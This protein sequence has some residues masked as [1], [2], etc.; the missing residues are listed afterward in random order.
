MADDS[1]RYWHSLTTPE[2]RELAMRDPVVILPVAAIEQHG[3][4]LPLSTDLEI[5]R[6]ILEVCFLR[7]APGFPA[8]ALPPQVVG[9]SLEHLRFPGTLSLSP[10]ILGETLFQ[11]GEAVAR[12]GVRRLVFFNSHGGNR[13]VL[14]AAALRLRAELDVLVVKASYPRFPRPPGVDLPDPEWQHGFHGGAVETSMMLHLRSDLVR[15]EALSDFPSLGQ[16]LRGPVGPEGVAPFAWLAGDLNPQGV[17]GD[18]RKAD[19][20]SGARMVAHYGE[21]LA[22]IVEDTRNF[23]LERLR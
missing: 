12:S 3:P 10:E 7:L 8:W 13:P 17:V 18:P 14:D 6:G 5:G 20:S 22:E 11:L 4:H 15:M 23:P 1:I 19:P 9:S 21:I 2:A 16:E